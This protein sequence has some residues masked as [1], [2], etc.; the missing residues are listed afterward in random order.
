MFSG[1]WKLSGR[2]HYVAVIHVSITF[3]SRF[4]YVSVN[5]SVTFPSRFQRAS[6]G[7]VLARQE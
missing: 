1:P 4:C 5:V 6:V 2:F 7:Q 3:P